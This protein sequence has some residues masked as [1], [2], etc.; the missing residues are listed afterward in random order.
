MSLPHGILGFLCYGETTGYEL[1]KMFDA[2]VR[3]FWSATMSQ[4]YQDLIRLE[5]KGYVHAQ[6]VIQS[7]KPN[8]KVYSIT[9]AGRQ[10][11]LHW[12]AQNEGDAM[13]GVR[14]AL[15]MRVFFSGNAPPAQCAQML[16]RFKEDCAQYLAEMAT[17]PETAA[18]YGEGVDSLS[19]LYWSLT[20]DYGHAYTRMCMDWAQRCIDKLE[21]LQ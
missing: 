14:S 6:T 3:F 5:N 17:I 18:H 12:L 2:S 15:L 13:K 1:N 4:I 7:G 10:E 20:A 11:F 9:D 19:P 8:K 16:R 21:A